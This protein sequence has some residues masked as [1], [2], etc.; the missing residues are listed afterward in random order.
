M[1]N[2][3]LNREIEPIAQEII[4]FCEKHNINFSCVVQTDN[5]KILPIGVERSAVFCIQ[6]H[7]KRNYKN[8]NP[9]L[10][11]CSKIIDTMMQ[12]NPGKECEAFLNKVFKN[13]RTI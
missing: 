12:A 6:G 2:E 4:S 13:E 11:I 10:A 3:E 1:R 7:G 5:A 9:T 8:Y